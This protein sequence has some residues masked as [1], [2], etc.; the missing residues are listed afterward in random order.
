M[1]NITDWVNP[2][3]YQVS[4]QSNRLKVLVSQCMPAEIADQML[5]LRIT[6]HKLHVTT[7]NSATST[8][9]R[10]HSRE[11]LEKLSKHGITI[12]GVVVHVLPDNNKTAVGARESQRTKPIVSTRTVQAVEQVATAIQNESDTDSD[13]LCRALTRLAGH[14]NT[15][16][17]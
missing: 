7:P 2:S 10:F 9:I 1:K 5:F 4:A 11:M 14:L 15:T 6:G 17:R 16:K 8:R 12:N 3:L 13:Q